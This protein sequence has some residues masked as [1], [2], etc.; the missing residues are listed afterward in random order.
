MHGLRR[1]YEAKVESANLDNVDGVS[2]DG[3]SHRFHPLNNPVF[4]IEWARSSI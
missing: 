4:L 3:T 1:T 2:S